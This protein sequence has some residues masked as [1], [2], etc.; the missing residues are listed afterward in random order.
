MQ[1]FYLRL[2]SLEQGFEPSALGLEPDSRFAADV[3]WLG[4]WLY[5]REPLAASL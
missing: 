1:D 4:M 5:G 2:E 3:V